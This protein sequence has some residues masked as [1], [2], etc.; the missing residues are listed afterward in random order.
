MP[1][2]NDEI[3]DELLAIVF[4]W[5]PQNPSNGLATLAQAT[6]LTYG[7]KTLAYVI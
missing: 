4:P 1:L 3:E 7:R 5:F 2:S 6:S